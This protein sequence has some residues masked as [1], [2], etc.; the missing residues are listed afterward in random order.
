MAPMQPHFK[1]KEKDKL[2]QSVFIRNESRESV[3]N[4]SNNNNTYGE[5]RKNTTFYYVKMFKEYEEA[6][7]PARKEDIRNKYLLSS[8][9]SKFL[10][11][12]NVSSNLKIKKINLLFFVIIKKFPIYQNL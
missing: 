1:D 4:N 5:R 2:N 8:S 12:W 7:K 10:N 9:I 11:F 3:M 6:N